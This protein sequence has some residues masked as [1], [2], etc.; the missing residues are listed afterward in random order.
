MAQNSIAAEIYTT[1]HRILGRVSPGGRGL[2]SFLNMPT[3]SAVEIEGAIL[4]RL[5]QPERLIARFQT[6]WVV[7]REIS[8]ILV[9][10]KAEIGPTAIARSGYRSRAQNWVHVVLDDYELRGILETSGKF[11]MSSVMFEGDAI[12]LA[13]F[14]A[15]LTATRFPNVEAESVAMLFNRKMVDAIGLIPRREI[16]A[17]PP[18][19]S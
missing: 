6:L 9:S 2:F 10:N 13:L 4:S 7:K 5:Q 18:E 8:G 14:K 17:E 12:F 3:T 1:S 15:R 11:N 16:P 19:S